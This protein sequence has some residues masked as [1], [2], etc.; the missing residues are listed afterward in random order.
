MST[1]IP[2]P[3]AWRTCAR[4]VWLPTAREMA[5]FDR[6]AVESGA[7]SERALIESAGRELA[8]RV[9]FHFPSGTVTALAGAGHNGADA[10]VA[11]RT[12]AAWG[13][14][15]RLCRV[16]DR[17]VDPDVLAGWDLPI[18]SAEQF[19]A[20]PP[21]DGVIID[22]ILGTGLRGP[23]R[24]PVASLI[25]AVAELNLPIVAVD[26]PSGASLESGEVPGACIQADLTVT[27]GWPKLGLLRFPARDRAGVIESVEIGFPVSGREFGARAITGRWVRDLLSARPSD[28]HKGRAGYVA[29][30]AGGRGMAGAAVL[31]VRAAMRGGAGIVRAV[32]D[33]A[34]REI[35]QVSVPGAVFAGWD[36]PV[37]W[38]DAIEWS[39]AIAVGPG[40][41]RDEEA[42]K[43]VTGVLAARGSR[44]VVL[45][46]DGLS[47]WQ[48]APEGL[49]DLLNSADVITPHPGELA[50][51][52]GTAVEAITV[53][54]T[55]HV[56]EA[57]E[58]FGCAVVLKGAPTLVASGEDPILA[59]TVGG[60]ALA[61]GGTGDVLTGLIGA[62][63]GSGSSASAAAA[64]ALFLSGLAAEMGGCTEG[65]AAEDVPDRIPTIRREV[66]SLQ[67]DG[68]GP[69]NFVSASSAKPGGGLKP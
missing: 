18:E 17:P 54:P 43:L 27:F 14:P 64:S 44:P 56:R 46:A 57:A 19:L 31:A 60:P 61:A 62:L 32:S 28:A 59:T 30:V 15:V 13:R 63:L 34:N 33:P 68:E 41:G 66:E 11:A 45:D 3:A 40:L 55:T 8:H 24:E 35:L 26:G 52:L 6:R 38:R 23:P 25:R 53:D 12:L 16:T 48:E 37:H 9:Q 21:S 51:I 4:E 42:K 10:L 5:E 58:R 2:P 1:L 7:T 49:A 67:A 65:H 20:A 22:G 47:V 69:V 29:V 39:G 36:D 50:R